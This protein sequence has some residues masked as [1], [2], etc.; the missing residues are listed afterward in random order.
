MLIPLHT[1][2]LYINIDGFSYYCSYFSHDCDKTNLGKGRLNLSYRSKIQ[3]I[4]ESVFF[5]S[6]AMIKYL[7]KNT[8]VERVFLAHS[9]RFKSIMAG[10]INNSS[11]HIH[12][13]ETWHDR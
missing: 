8:L 10:E 11:C 5:F 9:S 6:V 13:Q 7:N 12:N 1:C 2:T 4:M 3:S